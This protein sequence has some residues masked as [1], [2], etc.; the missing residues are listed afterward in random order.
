MSQLT[1]GRAL[2]FEWEQIG[3]A[4]FEKNATNHFR[5]DNGY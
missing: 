5:Q 3:I 2:G 1:L 4:Y